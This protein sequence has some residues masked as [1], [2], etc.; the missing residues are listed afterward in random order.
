[1]IALALL[2]IVFVPMTFFSCT[3]ENWFSSE[4]LNAMGVC[5]ENSNS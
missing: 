1:M 3:L 5:L 4:E 2:L